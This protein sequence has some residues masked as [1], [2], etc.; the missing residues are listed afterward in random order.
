M[1]LISCGLNRMMGWWSGGGRVGGRR[2]ELTSVSFLSEI[3]RWA[4]DEPFVRYIVVVDIICDDEL[5][6]DPKHGCLWPL[7]SFFYLSSCIYLAD[8]LKTQV[9]ASCL[10]SGQD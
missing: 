1:V 6:I 2:S 4:S 3:E 9:R 8:V 5:M 7:G 10:N